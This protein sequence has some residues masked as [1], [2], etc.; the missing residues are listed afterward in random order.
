ML[1][2]NTRVAKVLDEIIPGKLR[3]PQVPLSDLTTVGA[4]WT[5]NHLSQAVES[6]GFVPGYL[7]ALRF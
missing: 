7:E 3:I 2:K 1:E 6:R 4:T 5:D